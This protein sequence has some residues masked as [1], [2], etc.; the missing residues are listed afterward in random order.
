MKKR[1]YNFLDD[2]IKKNEPFKVD[3]VIGSCL[4]IKREVY[5][6][7][8]GLDEAFFLYE[9]ETEW[10]YRMKQ[11]G[12]TSYMIP[13]ASAIHEHHSSTSKIGK[14]FIYYH[15]FRSR[16]IFDHKKF[17]GFSYFFRIL[18]IETGLFLRVIYFSIRSIFSSQSKIKLKAY[19][20]L[21]KLNSSSKS[22]ILSD[23]F[24]FEKKKSI[25]V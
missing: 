20:D 6:S 17:K 2:N 14:T 19:F 23:R 4:M 3:W 12:W 15:E 22:R 18:M 25:F 8:G 5:D 13:K 21:L 24:N 11:N 16:I 7:I 9:E 10:Q 1:I